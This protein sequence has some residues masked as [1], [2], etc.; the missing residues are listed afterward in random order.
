MASEDTDAV[1]RCDYCRLPTPR[2]TVTADREGHRYEFCSETCREALADSDSVFTEY[3]GHRRFDPGVSALAA[4]LPQGI[5]RNS[6]VLL[7]NHAG[8]R[9]DAI[10]AELAWRALGRGEP[11]V[12]VTFLEPP[13]SLIQRFAT[14][15]WNVLPYLES[16]QLRI[17]DCFTYRVEDRQR[18]HDRYNAWN[19]H[20]SS[21]AAEA[22][23]QV[24][25]PSDIHELSNRIDSALE[26]VDGG[27]SGIVVVDSLTEL[28]TLVQAVQAYNF[29]KDIRAEVC[30]GRFVPVFAGATVSGDAD[31]FPHDL[32]YM[33]DGIVELRLA[34][35]IVEGALIKQLRVRKMGGVLV[36]PERSVY[37]YTAGQGIVTF[38][39]V[40]EMEATQAT[41]TTGSGANGAS[42]SEPATEE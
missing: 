15:E 30:K 40:E 14:L 6:F 22:C 10:Q 8:T 33:V 27:D 25:D 12:F 34:D 32:Q 39:P 26:A 38:D 4:S 36:Y 3:H 16:G 9:T 17:V 28:G 35:D 18:M 11:V 2:E 7:T 13:V 37:E 29:V 24:R 41:E 20:L 21:V 23:T 5:P 42:G 1:D 31:A 19:T